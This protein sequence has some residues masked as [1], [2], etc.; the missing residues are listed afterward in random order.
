M[1]DFV[2]I[3][4]SV[5][6][7]RLKGSALIDGERVGWFASR[8]AEFDDAVVDVA[9]SLETGQGVRLLFAVGEDLRELFASVA[10]AREELEVALGARAA[11]VGLAGPALVASG[12]TQRDAA[13]LL[14][15][16]RPAYTSLVSPRDGEELWGKA[17]LGA[18]PADVAGD[19]LVLGAWVLGEDGLVVPEDSAVL[20]EGLRGA[21]ERKW[22]RAFGPVKKEESSAKTLTVEDAMALGDPVDLSS[23]DNSVELD[24]LGFGEGSDPDA[25]AEIASDDVDA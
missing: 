9:A 23:S 14:G 11:A 15:V 24:P 25:E 4:V 19:S 21:V 10:K 20:V 8:L 3:H 1:T 6:S 7:R 17:V 2:D 22:E 16:P 18:A 13:G 12:F 5:A